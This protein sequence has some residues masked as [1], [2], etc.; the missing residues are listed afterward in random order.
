MGQIVLVS[1][2]ALSG[3]ISALEKMMPISG[4]II[5]CASEKCNAI[6]ETIS[7]L[8]GVEVHGVLPEGRIIAVI[9]SDDVQG[10]VAL[11]SRMHQI[12]GVASVCL[13]YHNFEDL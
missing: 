10:E 6:A 11:V 7:S 8:D 5:T 4:V 12:D 1:P 3:P 2:E 9:E 13:V